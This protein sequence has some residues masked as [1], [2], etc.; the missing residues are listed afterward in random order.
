MT[1]LKSFVRSSRRSRVNN[2]SWYQF[3]NAC[4]CFDHASLHGNGDTEQKRPTVL[5]IDDDPDIGRTLEMRF[6]KYDV[7][8]RVAYFGTHGYFEAIT[9]NPDLILTDIGMPNGDGRFVLESLRNN[10][11][12]ADV[13]VV[14]LTGMRDQGLKNEMLGKGADAFLN[15]PIRFEDLVHTVGE[16]VDLRPIE[17]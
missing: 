3:K 15:K 6:R 8:L 7:D 17:D 16:F 1:S 10:K 14:V 9:E 2:R 5:C 12:T 13:P 4:L 11:K